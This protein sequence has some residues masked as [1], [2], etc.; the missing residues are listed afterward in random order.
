MGSG[1]WPVACGPVGKEGPAGSHH[2]GDQ[3]RVKR[4]GRGDQ[5]I[6]FCCR[7]QPTAAALVWV[8]ANDAVGDVDV[9][10]T[11]PVLF[12]WVSDITAFTGTSFC[13]FGA[14]LACARLRLVYSCCCSLREEQENPMADRM[15]A[16]GVQRRTQHIMAF[17]PF[18]FAL[19][20]FI[21]SWAQVILLL[22]LLTRSKASRS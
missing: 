8:L 10:P 9:Q 7:L 6:D 12:F 5:P 11:A 1:L 21:S 3:Y 20:L 2:C 18:T 14:P 17:Y 15:M 13:D 19:V 22:F 16:P 4:G